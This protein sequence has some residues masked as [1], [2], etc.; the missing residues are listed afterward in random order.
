MTLQASLKRYRRLVAKTM[1]A[2]E[3]ISHRT[4]KIESLLDRLDEYLL[5][6]DA[7]RDQYYSERSISL[8]VIVQLQSLRIDG[9]ITRVRVMTKWS[10]LRMHAANRQARR[11]VLMLDKIQRKYPDEFSE[12][13]KQY[14]ASLL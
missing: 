1:R 6:N 10:R 9:T 11:I 3:R 14:T 12:A 4:D 2:N 13:D 8:F 5:N 7:A